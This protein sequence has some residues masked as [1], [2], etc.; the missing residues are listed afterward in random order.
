M[1]RPTSIVAPLAVALLLLPA[2]ANAAVGAAVEDDL[3]LLQKAGE[4]LTSLAADLSLAVTDA[5]TGE[6]TTRTGRFA[7]QRLPDGDTRVRATFTKTVSGK[8]VENDRRDVLLEGPNLTDRDEKAKKLTVRQVRKPGEKANLFKLGEGPFPLPIG[9]APEA[10]LKEFD[11]KPVESKDPAVRALDLLPKTG[12]ALAE[13]F[14][15][16]HVVFD[17]RTGFPRSI[18]TTDPNETATT[19]ATLT[20]VI[21]NGDVKPDEFK[22]DPVPKDW[23]VVQ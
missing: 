23:Q 4:N 2:A 16:I 7:L 6:A 12:T 3:K 15:A 17:A 14:K 21:E 19:T 18:R 8:R 20:D 10:V 13:K 9:Q 1:N 22:L 5:D 11:V